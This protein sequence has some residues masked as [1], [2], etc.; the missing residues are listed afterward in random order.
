MNQI[1]QNENHAKHFFGIKSAAI[2]E[3][4]HGCFSGKWPVLTRKYY[5][6]QKIINYLVKHILIKQKFVESLFDYFQR[7]T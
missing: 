1:K 6:R 3:L 4:W 2:S 7:K 5:I